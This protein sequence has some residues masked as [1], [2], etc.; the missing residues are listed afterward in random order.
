MQL[1]VPLIFPW[2]FPVK[3]GA[4]TP[5]KTSK[6]GFFFLFV[7]LER[8]LIKRKT[9]MFLKFGMLQYEGPLWTEPTALRDGGLD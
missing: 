6:F 7:C 2:L 1:K 4:D 8:Q 3:N 9:Q 5:L